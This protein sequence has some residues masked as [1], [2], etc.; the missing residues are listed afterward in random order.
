MCPYDTWPAATVSFCEARL[1]DAVREPSN[2]W[3]SAAYVVAGILLLLRPHGPARDQARAI[4]LTTFFVG[5]GSFF[6]HMTASFVGEVVDL[7]TMYLV[8]GLMLSL[9]LN[10]FLKLERRRFIWLYC[11][12][13][14]LPIGL[15]VWLRSVG[16]AL[17]AAQI[18]TT[19][20]LLHLEPRLLPGT[21]YRPMYWLQG[22]YAFASLIWLGDQT[23]RLCAPANHVFT[24]HAMWHVLGATCMVIFA[25]HRHACEATVP[26][27]ASVDPGGAAE[28]S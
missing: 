20:V 15:V 2:A 27:R 26:A 10:R 22:T 13:V 11:A 19:V 3:S 4:G 25:A 21:D 5:F 7:S 6:F 28:L 16:I 23:G 12:L 1:C 17:F 24:G 8:S 9:E 18:G 14:V